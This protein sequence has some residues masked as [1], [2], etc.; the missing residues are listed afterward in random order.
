MQRRK[1]RKQ[2]QVVIISSLCLLLCLCVGYAAFGT[3]LS[4]RATGHIKQKAAEMLK[5]K[6]VTSGDGLYED[7]YEEGRYV[8]KGDNPNNYITFSGEIWRIVSVESDNTIKIAKDQLLPN[9]K[10]DSIGART[11]G[12]CSQGEALKY[13]CNVWSATKNMVGSPS[14][15]VNGSYRGAVSADSE[16]LTYLNVDYYNSLSDN[17]KIVA[18][19]FGIGPVVHRN[20]NMSEQINKENSYLWYGK[21]GMLTPSEYIRANTNKTQCGNYDLNT[22]NYTTCQKSN[23]LFTSSNYWWTLNPRD[24]YSITVCFIHTDGRVVLDYVSNVNGVRPA[25]YLKQSISF[26]GE[27]TAGSPYEFS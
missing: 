2:K 27:G 15:Y 25:V 23:Y 13:G 26:D 19:N 9:R 16:L 11:T 17:D 14:E 20:T 7:E 8:F 21:V 18:H 12:F 3:Q 22:V 10:F 4:I 24:T 5:E 1:L 6:V